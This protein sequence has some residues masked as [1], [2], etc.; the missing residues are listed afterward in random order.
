MKI[1]PAKFP[2]RHVKDTPK[3]YPSKPYSR[4]DPVKKERNGYRG[5]TL[6]HS[7]GNVCWSDTEEVASNILC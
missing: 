5:H 6:S 2:C 1:W 7:N 3:S 4:K